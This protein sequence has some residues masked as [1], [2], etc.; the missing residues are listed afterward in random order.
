LTNRVHGEST[1]R[2]IGHCSLLSEQAEGNKGIASFLLLLLEALFT[3]LITR[4]IY[5]NNIFF[6]E[7]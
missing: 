4:K 2:A 7:N 5:K 6:K 3:A 1:N